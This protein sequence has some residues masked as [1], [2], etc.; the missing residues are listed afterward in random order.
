M[1]FMTWNIPCSGSTKIFSCNVITLQKCAILCTAPIQGLTTTHL[2][3]DQATF[4]GLTIVE[5]SG[6]SLGPSLSLHSLTSPGTFAA[7]V[8]FLS[9][10]STETSWTHRSHHSGCSRNTWNSSWT[11]R[12][13]NKQD[14]TCV[15]IWCGYWF[16]KWTS[17]PKITGNW[18]QLNLNPATRIER[19]KHYSVLHCMLLLSGRKYECLMDGC[20]MVSKVQRISPSTNY[21]SRKSK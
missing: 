14:K 7:L 2:W 15:F 1:E 8:A 12:K 11:C 3:T 21:F 9:V 4:V 10:Y 5:I 16:W 19:H 17:L 20:A 6:I 13:Q 18:I